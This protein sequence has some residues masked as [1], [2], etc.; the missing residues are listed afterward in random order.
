MFLI[1][2]SQYSVS[3]YISEKKINNLEKKIKPEN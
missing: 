3:N 1:I 2:K